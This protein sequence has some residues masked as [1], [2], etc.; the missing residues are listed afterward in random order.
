MMTAAHPSN[1]RKPSICT[2][3]ILQTER[4]QINDEARIDQAITLAENDIAHVQKRQLAFERSQAAIVTIRNA[5]LIIRDVRK[6]EDAALTPNACNS[7]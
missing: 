3:R 1:Y 4:D 6:K 5:V 7:V 2:K